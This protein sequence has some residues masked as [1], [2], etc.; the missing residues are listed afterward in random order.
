MH[1]G[2]KKERVGYLVII[3]HSSLTSKSIDDHESASKKEFWKQS[4]HFL[5]LHQWLAS[6]LATVS[7]QVIIDMMKM[8][9]VNQNRCHV[10]Q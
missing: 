3:S 4:R 6:P 7:E 9:E 5:D 1:V 8:T 2:F 10:K